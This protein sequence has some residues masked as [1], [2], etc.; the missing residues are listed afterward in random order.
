M[1]SVIFKELTVR[2]FLSVGDTSPLTL[3]FK[4][5]INVITGINK[6][7]EDSKNGVGKSTVV[8]ALYFAM[9][10]NTVREL[11]KE[12][13]INS[14]T[15]KKCEVKLTFEII[16]NNNVDK[17]IVTRTLS[18]TKCFLEKN[19]IDIT[20]STIQKTNDLIQKLIHSS[21][22]V[23]QNSVIMSAGSAIPFMSQSKVDKRK[24]IENILN[25]EVF[26][27][28]LSLIREE[29]NEFKKDYEITFSKK[30]TLQ[31][32]LESYETQLKHFEI[33]KQQKIENI[34]KKQKKNIE[35]IKLLTS[36]IK[37]VNLKELDTLDQKKEKILL[38]LKKHETELKSYE[39]LKIE[40]S[41][42]IKSKNENINKLKEANAVCPTCKRSLSTSDTNSV[43]QHI[44]EYLKEIKLLQERKQTI[45]EKHNKVFNSVTL[46]KQ[47]LEVLE[48]K[49]KDFKNIESRNENIKTKIQLLQNFDTQF[50][51]ELEDSKKETNS[52]LEDIIKTSSQEL[53]NYENIL[54]NLNAK[55]KIHECVKF[56][57]SEEGVKSYI[58][59]KILTLLNLRITY[60]LQKLDANCRCI[61]NEFF[62]DSIYSEDGSQRS[63]FNFS[64]G[65][66]KRIDLACLFAFLDIRRLQGDVN[67]SAIFY[68]EL[69]DS[70]LDD[71]GVEGVFNV[72]KERQELYN[73]S[74][75]IITHRGEEFIS[76][77]DNIIMLEKQN[78]ITYLLKQ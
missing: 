32:T 39:E 48:N 22:N 52:L 34:F 73:E 10:G 71:V 50:A 17:Y 21:E 25:L 15:G 29:Y 30:Q 51:Q 64:G 65:E 20:L 72:L 67:Y 2:N 76:K 8:D 23:F 3:V 43:Q 6:D 13:I 46:L 12:L 68:D 62:E 45:C 44:E 11:N 47:G 37:D 5:G 57:A 4:S 38:E 41:T 55:L 1:C 7:K 31:T 27:K 63:Y 33:N 75:Y 40:V 19:G 26:S 42:F 70:A 77:A 36:Q 24:F 49:K 54:N 14:F 61:F 56:I 74:S 58:V 53:A 28:M 78:G 69:F 18:P 59:K 66:R 60:Y 9:F 35:D 16:Q